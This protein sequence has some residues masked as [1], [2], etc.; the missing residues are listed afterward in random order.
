MEATISPSGLLSTTY[1]VLVPTQQTTKRSFIPLTPMAL[2]PSIVSL[3]FLSLCSSW[4]F[5]PAL[6]LHR[7]GG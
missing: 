5:P 6:W 7:C 4:Q 1:I 2:S 3:S